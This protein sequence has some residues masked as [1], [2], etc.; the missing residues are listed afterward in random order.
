M[1]RRIRKDVIPFFRRSS[2]LRAWARCRASACPHASACLRASARSSVGFLTGVV[3]GALSLTAAPSSPAA[4]QTPTSADTSA[5]S[6]ASAA[7]TALDGDWTYFGGTRAFQRYSP[8]DQV[9]AGNVDRLE[10]VWRRPGVD[11]DYLQG[12]PDLPVSSYLSATP[13]HVNGLLYAPNALGFVEA[14]DPGTGETVWTQEPEER[15]REGL[16]GQSS[17]GVAYWAEANDEGEETGEEL[18]ADGDS[19]NVASRKAPRILAVRGPWLHALDPAT[20]APIRE[21]G[22]GG[23]VDLV[24]SGA[25]SFRWSSGPITAGDVIVVGG[26]LDGAGDSGDVWRNTPPE[27]VR[28]FDVRTGEH[29]WTFHVVPR[30]GELGTETWTNG[31]WRWSGDLGSWC[32]L[33][34]DEDLGIVYVPLSAPTAAYYGGHRP[35]DNLF[36]NSLV[37][38]DARTGERIWHFQMVHHDVWE[39]D[40]LGPP[41]L[42]EVTVEGER[43]PAVMQPNK[44]SYL[45]AFHRETGE[46]VWPI[47]ERPV[48]PSD[49]PGEE[50]SPTQPIPTRPLPF[51]RVGIAEDDL[52]DLTPELRERAR[53]VADSFTI[54]P[55]YTP[56]TLV[57]DEA[58][59]NRGTLL[60]PGSWG[61]A[62]WN[63]GAFDPETGWYYA[64]S[65]T[66]PRVY[67]IAE[68]TRDGAEMRYYSPRRDAPYLDGLPLVKPP[69]GRITAIDMNR[70]EHVWMTPNG[71]G[72]RHHPILDEPDLPHRGYLGIASRPAPLVTR[73]LLFVGE[74]SD[75]HG[76]IPEGMWGDVFRAYDKATGEILWEETLP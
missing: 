56:P 67:R 75:V 22:D 21:F 36:S 44:N 26:T 47:E 2:R 7:S 10:I 43:I 62:N 46:P 17:R 59:G 50:L 65:H 51:D 24:P 25:E 40:N 60:A 20:G 15:S 39:Y 23:R 64:V 16:T 35:G 69:W 68:A 3:V 18:S 4:A 73:T 70:G 33:S 9:H 32:C 37:A 49:I 76:G 12:V 61:A 74:G 48:P 58:G 31:A 38:L 30:E 27:D 53:A 54:G 42:G 19:G 5:A 52:L 55:L 71:R 6:E 57:S 63:T 72:P 8:L 28:G 41:V 14:F 34:A 66:L 45:F 29:L 1:R 13:I 11:S